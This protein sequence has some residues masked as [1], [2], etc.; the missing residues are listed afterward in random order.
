MIRASLSVE[1]Q[2]IADKGNIITITTPHRAVS[3]IHPLLLSELNTDTTNEKNLEPKLKEDIF[4]DTVISLLQKFYIDLKQ[5]MS[6]RT[7]GCSV[8]VSLVRRAVQKMQSYAESAIHC[9]C[10]SIE[11]LYIKIIICPKHQKQ[12][13]INEF[14]NNCSSKRNVV[15]KTVLN[16]QLLLQSLC[17][18]RWM[19]RHDGGMLFKKSIPCFIVLCL[20][21]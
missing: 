12:Y 8:K 18:T 3:P 13:S 20:F 15:L 4:G 21:I 2:Q 7:N 11:S 10:T 19:E 17:E 6:V 5:C 16:D 1:I 9:T 14:F